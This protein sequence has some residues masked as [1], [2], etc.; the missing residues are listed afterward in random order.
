MQGLS[1]FLQ[2]I[3]PEPR[4]YLPKKKAKCGDF[5]Q[6]LYNLDS[7][8]WAACVN[9]PNLLN[10]FIYGWLIISIFKKKIMERF[11]LKEIETNK[12]IELIP[13]FDNLVSYIT[14]RY[15]D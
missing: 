12:T 9:N 5:L 8:M 6:N 11:I 7:P 14:Q 1:R 3:L 15:S 10:F 13:D 4:N 2:K